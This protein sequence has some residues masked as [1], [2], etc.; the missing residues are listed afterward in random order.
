MIRIAINGAGGR[1]GG[2][3]VALTHEDAELSLVA[4]IEFAEHPAMGEDIGQVHH[5][6]DLGVPLTTGLDVDADVL[7]DF[8]SPDASVARAHE[9][10]RRGVAMVVGTTGHIDEQR[11]IIE[12]AAGKVAVLMAPN[13]SVGVNLLFK[14]TEEVA[15]ILGQDWDP[16]IVEVHH[17]FKKDA[18][19][20]TALRLAERVAAGRGVDLGDVGVYGRSGIVGE[21][22]PAEIAVHAVRTGDVVGDHTV[23]F[24]T[25]GERIE[26]KHQAHTRD[27][28]ARGALRAAKFVAQAEAGLYGFDALLSF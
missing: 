1:M 20:G 28:F 2:R 17:R 13:M 3:L 10:A 25:L 9:C 15:R 23:I 7:I 6:G 24:G 26:L 12:E 19:S 8:S 18:P 21:R 14:L 11:A 16:E 22:K 4:A 5:M 27:T